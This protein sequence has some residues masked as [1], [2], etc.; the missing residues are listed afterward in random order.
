MSPEGRDYKKPREHAHLPHPG[1][2]TQNLVEWEIQGS[3][4]AGRRQEGR[5]P[6]FYSMSKSYGSTARVA[7]APGRANRPR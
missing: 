1:H 5:R 2:A 3:N 4:G 6:A 7:D